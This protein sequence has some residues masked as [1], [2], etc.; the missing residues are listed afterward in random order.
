MISKRPKQFVIGGAVLT[1]LAIGGSAGAGA[2][3]ASSGVNATAATVAGRGGG[4]V[5][6]MHHVRDRWIHELYLTD[7][8]QHVRHHQRFAS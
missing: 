7:H 6:A 2:A 5:G 8:E 3:A 4:S 1:A